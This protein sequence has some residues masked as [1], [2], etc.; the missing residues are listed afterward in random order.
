MVFRDEY[1]NYVARRL[2]M[3]RSELNRHVANGNWGRLG[4]V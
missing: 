4:A 2:G 3:T 1:Y